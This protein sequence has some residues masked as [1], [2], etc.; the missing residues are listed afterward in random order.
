MNIKH[1]LES[2]FMSLATHL[3]R[4]ILAALGVVLGVGAVV[5]MLAISEGARKEAMERIQAQG[6]DNL[7]LFS[8]ATTGGRETA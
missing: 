7:V 1:T 5:G 8:E 4:S 2:T 3:F 6:V